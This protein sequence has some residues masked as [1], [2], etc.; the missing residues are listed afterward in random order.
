MLKIMDVKDLDDKQLNDLADKLGE[1]HYICQ[2]ESIEEVIN[3][4]FGK[5]VKGFDEKLKRKLFKK[6]HFVSCFCEY[7]FTKSIVNTFI[8]NENDLDKDKVIGMYSLNKK[9]FESLFCYY[10]NI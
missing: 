3:N 5:E 2:D 4:F 10:E 9:L 8:E 7:N 1:H 6:I